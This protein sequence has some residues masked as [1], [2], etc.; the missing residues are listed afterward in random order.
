MPRE[1]ACTLAECLIRGNGLCPLL[2]ELIPHPV[3]VG[4]VGFKLCPLFKG[5][6][7]ELFCHADDVVG[8]AVEGIGGFALFFQPGAGK[9]T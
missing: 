7:A 5:Q 4:E 6:G 1:I 2:G 3:D 9:I 8:I